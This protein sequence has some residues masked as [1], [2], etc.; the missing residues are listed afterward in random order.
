MMLIATAIGLTH[1]YWLAGVV[2]LVAGV[3]VVM[4]FVGK[5]TAPDA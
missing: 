2:L 5:P 4:H 1:H 3:A